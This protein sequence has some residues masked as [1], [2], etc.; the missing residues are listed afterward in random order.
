MASQQ[1]VPTSEC[2]FLLSCFTFYTHHP[3]APFRLIFS[4]ILDSSLEL[5]FAWL[6]D[7]SYCLPND[8]IYANL[9]LWELPSGSSNATASKFGT[10]RVSGSSL[11]LN[12]NQG[13]NGD[14]AYIHDCDDSNST[15]NFEFG[16]EVAKLQGTSKLFFFLASVCHR[17]LCFFVSLSLPASGMLEEEG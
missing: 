9:Q 8:S 17:L 3:L 10:F 16:F 14:Q 13:I 5:I 2:K 4:Y 7:R 11:C 1:K 15:E 6:V 12:L